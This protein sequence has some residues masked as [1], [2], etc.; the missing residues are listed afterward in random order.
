MYTRNCILDMSYMPIISI[1]S[2]ANTA[3]PVFTFSAVFFRLQIMQ[4]T[5][6]L[7]V[8]IATGRFQIANND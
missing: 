2:M 7:P 4:H 3:Y 6:I 8:L 1:T 5:E